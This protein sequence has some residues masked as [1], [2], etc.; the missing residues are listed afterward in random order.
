MFIINFYLNMFRASLSPS[1]GE[2]RP[3]TAFG[4][5]FWFCWM[6][7][8]AVVGRCLAGRDHY[9]GFCST[10]ESNRIEEDASCFSPPG[11]KFNSQNCV[12]FGATLTS[13]SD[14]ASLNGLSN[15]AQVNM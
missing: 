3:L 13:A 1:S 12:P 5:L 11:P 7:L 2:Q 9:E 14:K 8:I 10:Q 15:N 6:L 4:V